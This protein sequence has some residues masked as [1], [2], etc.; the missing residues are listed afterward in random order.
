MPMWGGGGIAQNDVQKLYEN[1]KNNY[2]FDSC[3][4]N[5]NPRQV[6]D[7]KILTKKIMLKIILNI[8]IQYKNSFYCGNLAMY[9][10]KML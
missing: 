6:K 1:L 2:Y 5:D 3:T 7:K 4:H 9:G 8:E 10:P